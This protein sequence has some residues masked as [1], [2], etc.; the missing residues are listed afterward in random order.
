LR[1]QVK[2]QKLQNER[3]KDA[4]KATGHEF[5]EAI[6]NLFGYKVDALPSKVYRLSSLYAQAPDHHLIFK[7]NT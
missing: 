3:L 2:T 4:F 1:E 6:F 7:V 5:R